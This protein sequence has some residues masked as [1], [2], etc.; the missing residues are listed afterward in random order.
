MQGSRPAPGL[1]NVLS[2]RERRQGSGNKSLENNHSVFARGLP[3][4]QHSPFLSVVESY[5]QL[6]QEQ[7]VSVS[8][9]P[10]YFSFLKFKTLRILGT[11]CK[12]IALPVKCRIC[13]RSACLIGLCTDVPLTN[14]FGTD[15]VCYK[16]RHNDSS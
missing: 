11:L 12:E 2:T 6:E 1:L 13:I 9:Q 8:Q 14:A 3:L 4:P 16:S 7:K 10:R 15:P 5:F